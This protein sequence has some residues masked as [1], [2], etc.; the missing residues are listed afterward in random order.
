MA[1]ILAIIALCSLSIGASVCRG[2]QNELTIPQ[3]G[4]SLLPHDPIDALF[5]RPERDP[6]LA[7][8]E[9]VE[10]NNMPFRRAIRTT[11]FKEPTRPWDTVVGIDLAHSIADGDVCMLSFFMRGTSLKDESVGSTVHACLEFIRQPH[12]KLV[13]MPLSGEKEWRRIFIPFQAK[14]AVPA[15]SGR[16]VFHLG[17]LPQTVEIGGLTVLNFGQKVSLADLPAT[18]LTYKGREPD[19]PWRKKALDRIERIRKAQLVVE[20][21]DSLERPVG[22]ATVHVKMVRH[23]FGFG[24]AVVAGLLGVNP[25]DPEAIRNHVEEFGNIEGIRTYRRMVEKLFNK[26]T[27]ENDL[28]VKAWI[29]SRSNKD[30]QYRR[31]WTDRALEWLTE[32]GIAVRGHWLACGDLEELPIEIVSSP[33]HLVRSYLFAGM[34]ERVKAVGKWIKEW[35]AVNHIVGGDRTLEGLF[36][37]PDIYVEIMKESRHLAPGAQLWVNEGLVLAGGYR[38]EPYEKVIRYLIDRGAAPD[39]IGFMG[40]FDRVSLTSPDELL[41]VMDRFAGLIPRLQITELDVDVGND[42]LLQADYLRDAM[43]VA[44]SHAA[45]EAIVLWGF[46][47][48]CHWKPDAALYR[49][50][51]SLKPAGRIWEDLLFR[52]WWTDVRGNTDRNGLYEQRGFLGQYEVQVISDNRS[53]TVNASLPKEGTKVRI[54]LP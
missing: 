6:G 53:V 44:F 37:S 9:I 50:D 35:D 43:T 27:L 25:A 29:T 1:V 41:R 19:A 42:E 22:D 11:T 14:E 33:I 18:P 49:K 46:W 31:E 21:V 17:F 13:H 26:A 3:G 10:V 40:H 47:E 38:R 24:S 48:N 36:G 45:C 15:K 5:W 52:D 4:V 20:V 7:R 12:D 39:G 30:S 16:V 8:S 34:R 28:K 54:K 51:W 32:R 2:E 23:T